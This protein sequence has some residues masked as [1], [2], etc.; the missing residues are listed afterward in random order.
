MLTEARAPWSVEGDGGSREAV[1][2][3]QIERLLGGEALVG[4]LGS[5]MD[6]IGLVRRGVP[7]GAV[8]YFADRHLGDFAM[9]DRSVMP[10]RTFRRREDAGQRLDPVESDRLLRLVRLVA[11]AEDTFGGSEKALL[12]LSRPTRALQGQTPISLSDTDH[13]AQVVETLLGRIA[14][15][16][17]A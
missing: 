4:K 12:W 2:A 17:A 7:T 9:I 8:R 13:G 15:G 11:F 16:I 10:R 1:R 14:H 3:T 6:I 5:D